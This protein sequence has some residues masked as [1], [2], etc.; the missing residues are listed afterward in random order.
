VIEITGAVRL[1][2]VAS[3]H[4]DE[5]GAEPRVTAAIGALPAADKG[6]PAAVLVLDAAEDF[7]LLWYGT[8]ELRYLI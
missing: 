2:E 3:L 1:V 8:Q 7:D 5:A 6:D 4:V